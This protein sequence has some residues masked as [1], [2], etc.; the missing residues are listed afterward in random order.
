MRILASTFNLPNEQTFSTHPQPGTA[1]DIYQAGIWELHPPRHM[2]THFCV[3]L[4]FVQILLILK[5]S[6]YELERCGSNAH[7]LYCTSTFLLLPSQIFS[8][9]IPT[10]FPGTDETK[11]NIFSRIPKGSGEIKLISRN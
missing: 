9:K 4:F 11:N 6:S 1:N 10:T 7:K 8:N 2:L 5:S 3:H